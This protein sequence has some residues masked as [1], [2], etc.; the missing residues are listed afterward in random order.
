MAYDST[1]R[2]GPSQDIHRPRV[3][4]ARQR[5]RSPSTNARSNQFF[6]TEA[7]STWSSVSPSSSPRRRALRRAGDHERRRR[8][9]TGRRPAPRHRAR[10][11]SS[12]TPSCGSRCARRGLLTRDSARQGT[13]EVRH[14]GRAQALPVQQ[15]LSRD[16]SRHAHCGGSLSAIAMKELLEAGVHFGHQ[17]KRWNPKMKPYIFGERNGIYI[18]DLG[19]TVKLYREAAEFLTTLA[20]RGRHRAVRRHQAPGAGRDRGRSAALRHVLRQPAL[21]GRPAD[22]LHDHPAQPRPAPRPRGHG[23]PTAATRRCR[24]RRS[25]ARE[26]DAASSQKNLD[27]IRGMGRL[28]DA[29]FVVDTAERAD[30]GRRGAQA[31]D[32]G[33]R[34]RRHQLRSGRSGLRDPGQRRRA[35]RRSGCSRPRIAD[36]VLGGRGMREAAAAEQTRRDAESRDA[37]RAGRRPRPARTPASA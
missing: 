35:A 8:R 26:G 13:Q 10:A 6:P 29:V 22:Q 1:L 3:S 30:R 16:A 31:E 5:A 12:T 15:A 28:P 9:R 20:E 32:S 34:R 4:P 36:A 33:H 21:A 19:K 23:R 11:A 7:L 14:G 24:R 37:P 2:H 17:T 27:G 18:I 25:R